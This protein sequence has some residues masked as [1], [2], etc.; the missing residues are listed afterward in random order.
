MWRNYQQI[1]CCSSST[2]SHF[3]PHHLNCQKMIR[4]TQ[5]QIY[6]YVFQIHYLFISR[7]KRRNKWYNWG[8]AEL[9]KVPRIS[10]NNDLW[11]SD[12]LIW[13]RITFRRNEPPSRIPTF[14]THDLTKFRNNLSTLAKEDACWVSQI[15][16]KEDFVV[17]ISI[18]AFF[19]ANLSSEDDLSVKSNTILRALIFHY[20]WKIQI[21][22]S[23][24]GK[25]Q[26]KVF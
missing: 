20:F 6:S 2:C 13:N 3:W 7:V 23:Y 22:W 4:M 5:Y 8:L 21:Y 24:L 17:K 25:G 16:E 12:P 15:N 26:T 10:R 14:I 18:L 9:E 1:A 11:V 19:K